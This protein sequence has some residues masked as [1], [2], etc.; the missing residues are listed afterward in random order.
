MF[1]IS[2]QSDFKAAHQLQFQGGK[3]ERLHGHNW[4]VTAVVGSKTLN[5]WGVIMDFHLLKERLETVLQ[6]FDHGRINFI[7]PFDQLNPTAENL[8][9]YI[10]EKLSS[11]PAIPTTARVEKVTVG[12]A[13]TMLASFTR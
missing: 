11:D 6:A 4:T 13:G 1:E 10:F 2:V 3:C 9:Q 5:E 7:P 12:E 8:A